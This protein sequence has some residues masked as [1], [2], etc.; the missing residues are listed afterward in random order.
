LGETLRQTH[1]AERLAETV[2][3]PLLIA[4]SVAHTQ[5]DR[6][7]VR[8]LLNVFAYQCC[9]EIEVLRQIIEAIWERTDEGRDHESC[10]W[11]E[12]MLEIGWPVVIG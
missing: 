2:F 12:V 10:S 11:A 3:K 5:I 8:R 4:A 1:T 7:E 6:D 9:Y